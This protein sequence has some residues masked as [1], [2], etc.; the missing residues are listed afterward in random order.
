MTLIRHQHIFP[1]SGSHP[2]FRLSS[3]ETRQVHTLLVKKPHRLRWGVNAGCENPFRLVIHLRTVF[4]T[5]LLTLLA[6]ALALALR[7]IRGLTAKR[8]SPTAGSAKIGQSD[9]FPCYADQTTLTQPS[10]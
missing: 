9:G 3:I 5:T 4:C 6:L 7:F 10:V 1:R 8:A 2:A